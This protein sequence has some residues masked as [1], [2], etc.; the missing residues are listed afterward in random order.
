MKKSFAEA[1]TIGLIGAIAVYIAVIL[2]LPIWVMFITW[3]SFYLFGKS[4][5]SALM[6]FIQM[7]LG[8]II[9]VAMQFGELMLIPYIGNLSIPIMIFIINGGLYFATK[10]KYLNSIPA[11]FLGMIIWFALR[12]EPGV[13]IFTKLGATMIAGFLFAWL[14]ET[15]CKWFSKNN[16]L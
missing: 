12:E 14:N 7:V 9:A 2:K 6:V 5:K 4:P 8:V 1:L 11:Y 3:C 13:I 15:I 10:G 16:N